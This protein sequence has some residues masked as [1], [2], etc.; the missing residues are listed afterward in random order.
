M[1]YT[2]DD[3]SSSESE[4][5]ILLS[6][7]RL[8]GVVAATVGHLTNLDPIPDPCGQVILSI[9][10]R[11]FRTIRR[12]TPALLG[13]EGGDS[14]PEAFARV[15]NHQRRTTAFSSTRRSEPSRP[16]K[17]QAGWRNGEPEPVATIVKSDTRKFVGRR[18]AAVFSAPMGRWLAPEGAPMPAAFKYRNVGQKSARRYCLVTLKNLVPKQK[19]AR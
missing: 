16:A 14:T 11:Q 18:P 6:G 3:P 15:W 8:F 12:R 1:T 5:Q 4:G 2:Q 19:Y 7:N 9:S 13:R 17:Y 10:E